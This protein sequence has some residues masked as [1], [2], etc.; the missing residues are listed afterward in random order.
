MFWFGLITTYIAWK[1]TK[2]F[3]AWGSLSNP[4]DIEQSVP[5]FWL[6]H[7]RSCRFFADISPLLLIGGLVMMTIGL[8]N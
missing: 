7:P 6:N 4:L 1:M 5:E 8:I 2:L 3:G